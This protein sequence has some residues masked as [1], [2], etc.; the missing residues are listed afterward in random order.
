MGNS[1][2]WMGIGLARRKCELEDGSPWLVR[3]RPE[4]AN[5]TDP[6]RAANGQS[7]SHPVGL[8]GEEGIEDPFY[9]L[10]LTA[11]PRVANFDENLVRLR[12]EERRVGKECRS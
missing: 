5:M 7:H 9:R 12:S 4:A 6:D 2:F 1:R 11:P 8:G 3:H 10:G